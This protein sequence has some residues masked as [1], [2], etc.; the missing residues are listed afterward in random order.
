MKQNVQFGHL[1]SFISN[2][3]WMALWARSIPKSWAACDLWKLPV[4]PSITHAEI[5]WDKTCPP[6]ICMHTYIYT[7]R[8]IIFLK[9]AVSFATKGS[10]RK[11][12]EINKEY[13]PWCIFHSV[14]TPVW[15]FIWPAV[16]LPSMT[17]TGWKDFRDPLCVLPF[18]HRPAFWRHIRGLIVPF[19]C[20]PLG[21]LH[22]AGST[23]TGSTRRLARLSMCACFLRHVFRPLQNALQCSVQD[24]PKICCSPLERL[25]TKATELEPCVRATCN[26]S[27]VAGSSWKT[28][29]PFTGKAL[30]M[31]KLPVRTRQ[32]TKLVVKKR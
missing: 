32:K 13:E 28:L 5:F 24:L 23:I 4:E 15:H 27:E 20:T 11:I 6:C 7:F 1:H 8:A 17:K 18:K 9:G 26:H 22:L 29:L 16:P 30:P 14:S 21:R 31:E 25:L 2:F 19:P 3:S 10:E 12:S